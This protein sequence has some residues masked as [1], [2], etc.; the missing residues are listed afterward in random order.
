[1]RNRDLQVRQILDEQKMK[2]SAEEDARLRDLVGSIVDFE[3]HTRE[4]FGIYWYELN[5]ADRA[6]A[7]RLV[8]SL[9]QRSMLKKVYEYRSDRAQ[10]VSEI[11]DPADPAVAKVLTL[12]T[13]G[14]ARWEIQYR[15]RLN[16][17]EWKIV[18]IILQGASSVE[19]NRSTFYKEIRGSGA[20]GLLEKLRRKV[21]RTP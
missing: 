15:M 18:D 11:I 5:E 19:R 7:I 12:I 3:R 10:Y 2:P 20:R 1:L 21:D 16:G 4:S 13:R 8:T 6:E 9:L 14:E 17:A